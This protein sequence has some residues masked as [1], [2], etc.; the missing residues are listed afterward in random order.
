MTC[1]SHLCILKLNF[2]HVHFFNISIV[3]FKQ[4]VREGAFKEGKF[5]H[6][7]KMWFKT[8]LNDELYAYEVQIL[9]KNKYCDLNCFENKKLL[10]HN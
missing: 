7:H 10:I 4:I 3:V 2:E 9:Q 5:T 6:A 8:T 1:T